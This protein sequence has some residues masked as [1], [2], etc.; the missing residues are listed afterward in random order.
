[1]AENRQN[2]LPSFSTEG[3]ALEEKVLMEMAMGNGS[4]MPVVEE[5]RREVVFTL[6]SHRCLGGRL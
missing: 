4:S 2:Y 6:C 3:A 1:M 5:R